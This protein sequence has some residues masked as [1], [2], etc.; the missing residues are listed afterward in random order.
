MCVCLRHWPCGLSREQPL[1]WLRASNVL[2]KRLLPNTRAGKLSPLP[3]F[4]STSNCATI[5]LCCCCWDTCGS[6]RLDSFCF[7]W[8][9]DIQH[10]PTLHRWNLTKNVSLER[11]V[12]FVARGRIV[13]T[14]SLL[15]TIWGRNLA[16]V[17]RIFIWTSDTTL[18]VF[19]KTG[20]WSIHVPIV[21]F[22]WQIDPEYRT[23][24]PVAEVRLYLITVSWGLFS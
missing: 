18:N 7:C 11:T 20:L 1:R 8:T 14:R 21:Y 17:W 23:V 6:A 10:C 12:P 24:C 19:Y 9:T 16:R 2:V 22:S 3:H 5:W 13:G 15:L 4:I